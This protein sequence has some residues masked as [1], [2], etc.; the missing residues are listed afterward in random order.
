M[1]S[2]LAD[3]FHLIPYKLPLLSY[4]ITD[5]LLC[6]RTFLFLAMKIPLTT[7]ALQNQLFCVSL[8]QLP[9]TSVSLPGAQFL[10]FFS[11]FNYLQLSLIVK[12]QK[13]MSL[14]FMFSGTCTVFFF[15]WFVRLLTLRPPL[16][17][18]ASLG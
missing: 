18:C 6:F 2:P 1:S 5:V 15:I 17:Y 9:L 12:D 16:A 7:T 3:T 14:V 4:I 8:M 13:P 11:F 10:D